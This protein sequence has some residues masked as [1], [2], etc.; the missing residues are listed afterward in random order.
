MARWLTF[1]PLLL[2][3]VACTATSVSAQPVYRYTPCSNHSNYTGMQSNGEPESGTGAYSFV[4]HYLDPGGGNSLCAL[5]VFWENDLLGFGHNAF[6]FWDLT[7][8]MIDYSAG[9]YSCSVVDWKDQYH[10]YC[11]SHVSELSRYDLITS[12]ISSAEIIGVSALI[13]ADAWGVWGA[14]LDY[15]HCT[16]DYGF[17]EIGHHHIAEGYTESP[18]CNELICPDCS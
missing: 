16:G 11:A 12:R 10:T 3:A 15:W 1:V 8:L 7:T 5:Y 14:L 6:G 18:P 4:A 17:C 2:V 9:H 13:D